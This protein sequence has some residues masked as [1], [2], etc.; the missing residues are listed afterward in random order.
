MSKLYIGGLL[1]AFIFCFFSVYR[2]ATPT[3]PVFL[4]AEQ[5]MPELASMRAANAEIGARDQA[6]REELRRSGD[7]LKSLVDSMSRLYASAGAAQ[8]AQFKAELDLLNMESN[9]ARHK[10]ILATTAFS[11][12]RT[13]AALEE[14][15]RLIQQFARGRNYTLVL[16]TAPG[17]VLYGAGG[18]ADVSKAFIEYAHN[19]EVKNAK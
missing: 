9:V 19:T 5:I 15:N 8:R 7:S 18:R 11:A 2:W 12:Q 1:G 14:S 10:G 3:G 17:V 6:W 16:G 4:N 13:K